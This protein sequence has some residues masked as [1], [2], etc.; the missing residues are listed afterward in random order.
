MSGAAFS[1]DA[2]LGERLGRAVFRLQDPAAAEQAL[3]AARVERAWMVET[4][5]PVDRVATLAELTARGFRV[6]DTNVQLDCPTARLRAPLAPNTAW[7]VRNAR[8]DDCDAVCTLCADEMTTSRF[9]LDP[10]IDA[11]AAARVKHDWVGNFFA[12]KRGE[13]LYVVDTGSAIAG[14]LLVLERETQGIIDLIA[15]GPAA[16]G[17]GAVRAMLAAWCIARP[18]LERIVVGTQISNTRSL[19]AYEKL[20]FRVC[21]ASYVL[22]CHADA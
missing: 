21:G 13:G 15:V 10:R 17:T 16:R 2:F 9:H 14:F 6:V 19:R 11:V 3:A 22:H 20:G 1:R 8:P 7:T 18:A 5:V 12:G 4:K